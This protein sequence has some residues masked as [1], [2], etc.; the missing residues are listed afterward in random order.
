MRLI[1]A[2]VRVCAVAGLSVLVASYLGAVHP[3][4]DSLAVFRHWIALGAGIGAALAFA[5]RDRPVAVALLVGALVAYGPIWSARN[6]PAGAAPADG[7]AAGSVDV[8]VYTKNVLGGWGDNAALVADIRASGADLVLLQEMPAERGDLPGRLAETH[9]HQHICRF[10]DWSGIAVMSR[11][12]LD[13]TYCAPHR[14]VA[15]ARVQGPD[16]EIWAVSVHLPWP[17]P[18]EQA[19]V[20]ALAMPFLETVEGA[21]IVAGDFN[22]VPWSHTVRSVARATGTG[23]I[24]RAFD[25]IQVRGVD[26]MIDHVLTSG[27]G[28]VTRRALF[29]ADHH[30]LVAQIRWPDLS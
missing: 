1:K 25:T 2:M 13:E 8:T 26:F 29:G 23:R 6:A 11:W 14:S 19:E 7:G 17:Y 9:P 3:V 28:E 5:V 18:H 10:S 21:A 24:G 4:G 27:Q 15:A 16:R 20:L 22:M 12:P 30:G